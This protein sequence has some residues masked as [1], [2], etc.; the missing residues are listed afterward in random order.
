MG[1]GF[2]LRA[3]H[4]IASTVPLEPKPALNIPLVIFADGLRNY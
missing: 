3:L 1:W 2:E 4:L